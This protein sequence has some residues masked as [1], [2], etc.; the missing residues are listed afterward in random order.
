MSRP[1]QYVCQLQYGKSLQSECLQGLLINNKI[2]SINILLKIRLLSFYNVHTYL[3]R[4]KRIITP[5]TRQNIYY[6][7]VLKNK[8]LVKVSTA[9]YSYLNFKYVVET[10]PL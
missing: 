5:D 9:F 7:A 4:A 3:Q 1:C 2:L 10:Y 8:V 6:I